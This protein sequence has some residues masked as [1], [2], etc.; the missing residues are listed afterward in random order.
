MSL[1]D[2]IRDYFDEWQAQGYAI[3]PT[4]YD[5]LIDERINALTNVELLALI[6]M[7]KETKP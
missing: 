4:W 6:D 1:L 2:A 7:I 5:A 3:R